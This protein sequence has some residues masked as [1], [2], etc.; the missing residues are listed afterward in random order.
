MLPGTPEML[1]PGDIPLSR[2]SV[3]G[4]IFFALLAGH[5]TTGS[6]MAFMIYLMAI[7]PEYQKELHDELDRQLGSRPRQE[8][9]VTEDYN[10]L[11]KGF[12]GAI[13]AETLRLYHPS[14][15]NFRR[16]AVAAP[17]VDS[18]GRSHTIPENT[19]VMVNFGATNQD[20]TRW[21][22]R[23][24]SEARKKQLHDSPALYFDPHR[25]LKKDVPER[26]MPAFSVGPRSCIGKAFAQIE[27]AAFVATIFKEHS[28]EF[29]VPEETLQACGGDPKLAWERT[30]DDAIR[31]MYDGVK[32]NIS[33]YLSKD[34]PVRIIKR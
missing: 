15:W 6:P 30:R 2:K 1:E 20:P 31:Q 27:M 10:A 13:Q 7:Y 9:T 22:Q 21:S 32:A 25:W 28:V 4:D 24:I 12:L 18:H 23:E 17:V 5:E 16:A 19:M 11:Q 3:L 14:Q 29:V 26:R 34:L 8:W 33:I